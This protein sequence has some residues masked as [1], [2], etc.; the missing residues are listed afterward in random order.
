MAPKPR[1]FPGY[2]TITI[3]LSP[4]LLATINRVATR[5]GKS[6]NSTIVSLLW[7]ACGRLDLRRRSGN[8]DR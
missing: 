1:E 8:R 2:G 4:A 7:I 3:K 5:A 6:L